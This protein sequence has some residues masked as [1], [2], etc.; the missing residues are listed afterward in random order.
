MPVYLFVIITMKK[1]IIVLSFL[2]SG[3]AAFSQT[4][5]DMLI[6]GTILKFSPQHL[7]RG[8]LWMSGEFLNNDK[9]KAHQISMEVMYRQPTDNYSGVIK[10]AGTT[11]EYMYKYYLS[12]FHVEK[13]ITGKQTASGYY[14]GVFGQLGYYD[15]KSRHYTYMS[16]PPYNSEE[17]TGRVITTAAY[18]GFVIGLQKSLGESFYMDIYAGAGMRI[19]D[20]KI[21]S[22]DDG[23]DY[24]QSPGAYFIYHNGLLPKIGLSLGFGF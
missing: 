21:Q 10:G 20:S 11:M 22:S 12:R 6:P 3:S 1:F 23:F 13:S 5:T 4:K 18:P 14:V 15:E 17:K 19:S 9:R 2:V 8:G 7:I 24:K 16:G